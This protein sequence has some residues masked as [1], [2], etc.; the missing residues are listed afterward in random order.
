MLAVFTARG[1]V[2]DPQ[3][4]V[5][6]HPGEEIQWHAD[7]WDRPIRVF[8]RGRLA[9]TFGPYHTPAL[10]AGLRD[11]SLVCPSM[12]ERRDAAEDPIAALVAQW[13]LGASTSVM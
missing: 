1:P 7:S 10:F 4:H 12:V 6:F 5:L 11:G 13:D 2:K 9:R 8:R 3:G